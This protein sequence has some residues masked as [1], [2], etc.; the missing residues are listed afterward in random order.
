MRRIWIT[1]SLM[2]LLLAALALPSGASASHLAR[3]DFKS[4]SKYC[5]ALRAEMGTKA[6]KRAFGKPKRVRRAHRKCVA[7]RGVIEKVSLRSQ[8]PPAGECPP[9]TQPE[10]PQPVSAFATPVPC[11]AVPPA[12]PPA[13]P[14][15][16]DDDDE[17][18]A[19]ESEDQDSDDESDDD[20]RDDDGDSDD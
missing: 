5:K 17:D 1:L 9:G 15:G 8:A 2:A 10:P 4:V 13:Q 19:E 3:A 6:F 12:L 20:D 7:R 18:E 14:A 16:D 11:V